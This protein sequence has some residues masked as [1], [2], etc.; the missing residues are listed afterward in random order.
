MNKT[1][2][3]ICGLTRAEDAIAAAELGAHALGFVFYP[4]SPRH[5][6]ARRAAEIIRALPP[7]VTTVGLF[8]NANAAD[9]ASVID[10][11][12]LGLLQFHGDETS[13]YCAQFRRP[14]IKALRVRPGVDL[15]QYALQYESA[16]GLLLDAFVAGVP[17]GTGESFDWNLIPTKLPLPIVLSG[18]LNNGNVIEAIRRVRPCAVDVSSGIE[19]SPGIKDARKMNDFFKGVRDADG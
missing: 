12:P 4:P 19:S 5:I 2:V 13:D 8:V 10:E 11:V 17:G 6:S 15:L 1:I 9:V 3:K 14:Y 7:F 18:G 16:R